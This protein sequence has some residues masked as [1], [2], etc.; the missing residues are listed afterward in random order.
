[1]LGACLKR[2]G[3]WKRVLVGLGLLG[4]IVSGYLAYLHLQKPLVVVGV[5]YRSRVDRGGNQ[6]FKVVINSKNPIQSA[7][8]E[9]NGTSIQLSLARDF[10]NGTLLYRASFNPSSISPEEGALTGEVVVKD[11]EGNEVRY[12]VSFLANLEAPAIKDLKVEE[13]GARLENEKG[14]ILSFDGLMK[15]NE[16]AVF[17]QGYPRALKREFIPWKVEPLIPMEGQTCPYYSVLVAR[18]FGRAA[19]VLTDKYPNS[20][21]YNNE[22]YVIISP[23][24]NGKFLSTGNQLCLICLNSSSMLSL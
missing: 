17:I 4:L 9:L 11:R 22:P 18:V 15:E 7:T 3:G 5:E 23:Q 8:I 6:E 24:L 14:Y 13:R 10:G 12:P 21:G 19:L 20:M 1:V 2:V 16:I